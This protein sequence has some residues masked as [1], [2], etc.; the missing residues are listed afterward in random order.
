[1]SPAPS[2]PNNSTHLDAV[3]VVLGLPRRSRSVGS[4]W[5]RATVAALAIATVAPL[6]AGAQACSRKPKQPD[7]TADLDPKSSEQLAKATK[8]HALGQHEQAIR[9]IEEIL[10]DQPENPPALRL[11]GIFHLAKAFPQK[12]QAAL[13]RAARSLAAAATLRPKDSSIAA[14]LGLARLRAGN[15]VQAKA[16]LEE[17]AKDGEASPAR[18]ACAA[19]LAEA[20]LREG[21][22][23][24]LSEVP[25]L[26]DAGET[27]LANL[28]GWPADGTS[29]PYIVAS[30]IAE[31][32]RVNDGASVPGPDLWSVITVMR[33][34]GENLVF[35][36]ERPD[37][38]KRYDWPVKTYGVTPSCNFC[39]CPVGGK[40]TWGKGVFTGKGRFG[41]SA[42]IGNTTDWFCE[43]EISYQENIPRRMPRTA[44]RVSWGRPATATARAAFLRSAGSALSKSTADAILDGQ[45]FVGMPFAVF[46]AGLGESSTTPTEIKTDATGTGI[47]ES[48]LVLGLSIEARGGRVAAVT[49]SLKTEGTA[50]AVPV[51]TEETP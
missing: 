4:P 20:I 49:G 11:A 31:A 3:G 43:V 33:R 40:P 10:A 45:W 36:E 19:W 8:L 35:V 12:D 38:L 27:K 23:N 29:G 5:S 2:E 34:E 47:I 16:T 24:E 30:K 15:L 26:F 7:D 32:H 28:A 44:A 9:I 51:Q 22:A 1:M 42:M 18:S 46:L 50:P 17:C 21:L 13:D 41:P 48:Y 14:A 25:H 6:G 37:T 39:T